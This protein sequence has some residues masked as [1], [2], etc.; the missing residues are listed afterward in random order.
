MLAIAPASNARPSARAS[1]AAVVASA[2][3]SISAA[4]HAT[5]RRQS[6]AGVGTV[7]PSARASETRHSNHTNLTV[8]FSNSAVTVAY[9]SCA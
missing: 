8:N 3:H 1:G 9:R 5:K 7:A 4:A 6:A 2:A